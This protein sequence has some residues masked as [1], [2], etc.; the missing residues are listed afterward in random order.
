[1]VFESR[2]KVNEEYFILAGGSS[3][4]PYLSLKA[5]KTIPVLAFPLM[6]ILKLF[7]KKWDILRPRNYPSFTAN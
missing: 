1:M 7:L 4:T 3:A 2:G 6:R 5:G